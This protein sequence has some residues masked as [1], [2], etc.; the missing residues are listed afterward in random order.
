MSALK[1]IRIRRGLVR[2]SLSLF[3]CLT[4]CFATN[5]GLQE[6]DEARWT[7]IGGQVKAPNTFDSV[8]QPTNEIS[9]SVLDKSN[10]AENSNEE[11][12]HFGFSS[13]KGLNDIESQLK[14]F[15]SSATTQQE[16]GDKRHSR[17]ANA[18]GGATLKTKTPLHFVSEQ[19][20]EEKSQDGK[21]AITSSVPLQQQARL[22]AQQQRYNMKGSKG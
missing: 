13:S 17:V 16:T 2:H 11:Q 10:G 18:L 1:E 5:V 21:T 15:P 8:E 20:I 14:S 12:R 3:L 22:L 9:A 7:Q 4:T 6:L 19:Q